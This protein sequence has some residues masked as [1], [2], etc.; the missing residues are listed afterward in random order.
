M[1]YEGKKAMQVYT[2]VHNL[3][4]YKEKVTWIE[5]TCSYITVQS[6]IIQD[7]IKNSTSG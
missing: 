3:C 5:A 6:D 4:D 2:M 1:F 7:Y